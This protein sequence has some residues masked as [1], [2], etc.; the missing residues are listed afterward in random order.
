[1]FL[2]TFQA[3]GIS[4]MLQSQQVGGSSVVIATG[5]GFV[6]TSVVTL[7]TGTLFLMWLGEQI[8]ERG[9]GNGISLLIFAGIVAGLPSARRVWR[10]VVDGAIAVATF[11]STFLPRA[12]VFQSNQAGQLA[13]RSLGGLSLPGRGPRPPTFPGHGR[14]LMGSY[15]ALISRVADKRWLRQGA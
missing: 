3:I 5:P 8:T 12:G 14:R 15:L 6:F 11:P 4:V 2:A 10:C 7:V 13:R 1:M 9:I